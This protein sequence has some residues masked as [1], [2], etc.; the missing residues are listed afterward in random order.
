[1]ARWLI[2]DFMRKTNQCPV[3]YRCTQNFSRPMNIKLTKSNADN[4]LFQGN[5]RLRSPMRTSM[6]WLALGVLLASACAGCIEGTG[7]P[8]ILEASDPRQSQLDWCDQLELPPPETLV[9]SEDGSI[10]FVAGDQGRATVAGIQSG[11]DWV[12][13]AYMFEGCDHALQVSTGRV[14]QLIDDYDTYQGIELLTPDGIIISSKPR[15]VSFENF[16]FTDTKFGWWDPLSDTVR[17]LGSVPVEENLGTTAYRLVLPWAYE[18]GW[19]IVRLEDPDAWEKWTIAA[20]NLESGEVRKLYEQQSDGVINTF[21]YYSRPQ[22]VQG[23]ILAPYY[24]R[25]SD[26]LLDHV[27]L[28]QLDDGLFREYDTWFDAYASLEHDGSY[29]AQFSNS[30]DGFRNYWGQGNMTIQQV[31]TSDSETI[32]YDGAMY[33]PILNARPSNTTAARVVL[34]SHNVHHP[35]D[36]GPQN[37]IFVW[38]LIKKAELTFPAADACALSHPDSPQDSFHGIHAEDWIAFRMREK[39]C[40]EDSEGKVGL[41]LWVLPDPQESNAG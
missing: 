19:L 11:S 8:D 34:A 35:P 32:P 21:G 28:W 10:V 12:A 4:K 17:E 14:F 38:D 29:A 41:Y 5:R 16:T 31:G 22:V 6:I 27:G 20:W 3:Q 2:Q 25:G 1:M 23:K 7:G 15:G 13:W 39:H 18:A 9:K 40:P 30:G 26:H 36:P 37:E 24:I 33:G